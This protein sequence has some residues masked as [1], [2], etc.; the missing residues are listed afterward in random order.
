M[1]KLNAPQLFFDLFE[2]EKADPKELTE[3]E[4]MI[5]FKGD[6]QSYM[7]YGNDFDTS[8]D[9]VYCDEYSIAKKK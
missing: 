4:V 8:F 6:I 3:E 9:L 1:P 5:K 2:Y 7:S